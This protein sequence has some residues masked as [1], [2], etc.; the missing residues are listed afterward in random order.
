MNFL[1]SE[2][3]AN[4]AEHVIPMGIN[5]LS[6]HRSRF[7]E[8]YPLVTVG[9]KG[10]VL[11]DVDR[12]SFVDWGGALGA[13]ILGYGDPTIAEVVASA[14]KTGCVFSLTHRG[15][16]N[17][18]RAFLKMFPGFDMVR[19]AKNGTD[20]TAG[21]VRLARA[22]TGRTKICS[23]GYHG[24][25]DVFNPHAS[26]NDGIPESLKDHIEEFS[27]GEFPNINEAAC[28]IL[29]VPPRNRKDYE[30]DSDYLRS[31]K[32]E[33]NNHGA[34]FILD[35]IV[36]GLR[37]PLNAAY[38]YYDIIP[39][40]ICMGKALANGLPISVIAGKKEIM[41]H[42]NHVFFS[43]TFAGDIISLTAMSA[44][45]ANMSDLWEHLEYV[46][47]NLKLK[48]ERTAEQ[49]GIDLRT[50]GIGCRW[51]FDFIKDGIPDLALKTLFLEGMIQEGQLFTHA[52]FPTMAHDLFHVNGCSFEET[53][54]LMK[55]A[56]DEPEKFLKGR[57][58]EGPY[59]R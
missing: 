26:M 25:H 7:P 34:L 56:W 17:A 12:N 37:H 43:T 46:G 5:T 33:T 49:H 44:V 53:F 54:E 39:D 30:I 31:L 3:L 4:E 55:E 58:M 1:T 45:L 42:F 8:Q 16:I 9:G 51:I 21:A 52:V 47:G 59:R 19:F 28:V 36:T 24:Y 40:I 14:I 23:M 38:Q 35:E 18:A 10:A 6:K 41:E 22:I 15:E 2:L 48:M 50:T 27:W 13:N 57:P 32:N 29:E 20:A 11:W